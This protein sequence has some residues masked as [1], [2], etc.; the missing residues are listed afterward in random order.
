MGTT[1]T[2]SYICL[3][4]YQKKGL[5]SILRSPTTEFMKGFVKMDLS[6]DIGKSYQYLLLLLLLF[7]HLH[8]T[9]LQRTEKGYQELMK[10]HNS[11]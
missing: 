1:Q 8:Q 10:S 2:K 3:C 6:K 5:V 11:G 4:S 9:S 7:I